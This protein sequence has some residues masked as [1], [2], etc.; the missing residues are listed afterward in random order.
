MKSISDSFEKTTQY[1]NDLEAWNELRFCGNRPFVNGNSADSH[2]VAAG[3]V[4]SQGKTYR[5]SLWTDRLYFC[6]YNKKAKGSHGTHLVKH[7]CLKEGYIF[8]FNCSI[9]FFQKR[10]VVPDR[11]WKEK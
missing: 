3:D 6:E 5:L 4:K 10:K 1:V 9:Y 8:F 7:E 2:I 11:Y